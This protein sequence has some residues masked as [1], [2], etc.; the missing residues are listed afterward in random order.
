MIESKLKDESLSHELPYWDFVDEPQAHAILFDGSLVG[1]LKVSLMDIECLD[2]NEV[3]GFTSGLRS[4]LN[5]IAE[6]TNL[7]FVMSVGSDFSK[8]IKNHTTGYAENIHPL[9]KTI[10]EYRE[11]KLNEAVESRELYKPEL[12]IYLRTP[13]VVQ[14][15]AGFLK[16]KEP[17]SGG[18]GILLIK[19]AE[20]SYWCYPDG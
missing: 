7:Q 12:C 20:L 19:W 17:R 10:A 2:D 15:K 13:M 8:T 11:R 9:V 16:K 18:S 6:G 5:S 1:G 4:A 3:N 14:K